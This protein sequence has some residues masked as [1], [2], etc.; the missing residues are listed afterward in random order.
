MRRPAISLSV[1]RTRRRAVALVLGLLLAPSSASVT[2]A[3]VLPLDAGAG[4]VESSAPPVRIGSR[5]RI[6]AVASESLRSTGALLIRGRLLAGD[7]GRSPY[8]AVINETLARHYFTA[9]D[10]IGRRIVAAAPGTSLP[11]EYVI[12]GIVRS[13]SNP[14]SRRVPAIYVSIAP[15]VPTPVIVSG[16]RGRRTYRVASAAGH[17]GGSD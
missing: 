7:D 11:R 13:S 6:I 1:R 12:V 14:G 2:S 4:G 16:S 3:A 5:T 15:I 8:G 17:A 10:P 9:I